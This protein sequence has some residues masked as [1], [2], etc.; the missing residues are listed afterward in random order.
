LD[1]VKGQWRDRQVV[2]VQHGLA[3]ASIRS[4][5]ALDG[6]VC[7]PTANLHVVGGGNLGDVGIERAA[8][9]HQSLVAGVLIASFQVEFDPC[10]STASGPRCAG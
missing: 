7:T 8:Q 4:A 9:I 3:G 2:K 10:V 5:C 1:I 6:D